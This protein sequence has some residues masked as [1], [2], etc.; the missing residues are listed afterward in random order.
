MTDYRDW[1]G[2][3]E[4]AGDIVSEGP[5]KAL[6]AL[7]DC[8]EPPWPDGE[9]PPLMHW[10]YFQSWVRQSEIDS[11][12][13]AKRGG[14]LPPV[15]LP[16]RMWAGSKLSF[17][18][19]LRVGEKIERLSTIKDVAQ[20]TGASGDLVFVKVLHGIFADGLAISEEQ[21]I[22]YRGEPKGPAP[23]PALRA[24]TGASTYTRRVMPDP[25]LL[26]RYSALTANGHRIHYDRDY[27]KAEGYSGLVVHGPLIAT[28]LVEHFRR[29]KPHAQVSS[30][31]IRFQMP[32]FDTSPFDL[33]LDERDGIASLWTTR[34]DGNV[35]AM[36]TLQYKERA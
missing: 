18:R 12:G 30:F 36:A 31:E 9:L 1:I 2:R 28:L 16:R 35:T 20:K 23:E 15:N 5:V 11:D 21:D 10:L 34:V 33:N 8:P 22:V 14:L 17:H 4:R 29:K 6:A 26:F 24:S 27:A 32:L 25:V 3:S 13:H 7:L 19:T